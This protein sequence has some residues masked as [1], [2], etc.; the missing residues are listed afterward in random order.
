MIVEANPKKGFSV[1][2]PPIKSRRDIPFRQVHKQGNIAYTKDPNSSV[3]KSKDTKVVPI[4]E[5]GFLPV[6]IFS[7]NNKQ[8]N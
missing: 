7:E 1:R 5:K 8:M 4:L 3:N 6:K 2:N